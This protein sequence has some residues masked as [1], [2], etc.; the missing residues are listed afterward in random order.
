MAANIIVTPTLGEAEAEGLLQ[1]DGISV[2]RSK[3]GLQGYPGLHSNILHQ[4]E[5]K[6]CDKLLIF[7]KSGL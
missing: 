2:L 7:V 4:R 5:K 6:E 3:F 1:V